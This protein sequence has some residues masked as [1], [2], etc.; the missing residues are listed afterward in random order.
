MQSDLTTHVLRADG[1]PDT[2]LRREWLITNGTGAFA[3]GT[4]LGCP[5]RRYHGLLVAATQPPVGRIMAL[6]QMFEQL[7]L[8]SQSAAPGPTQYLEL[9]TCQFLT[10]E[11]QRVFAP[12]G[13]EH[14]ECF[15]RG[16]HVS[17]HYQW[18]AVHITRTLLLHF[19]TQAAT[20]RYRVT[21]LGGANSTASLRLA[22]MVA[23]R[24]FHALARAGDAAP[25]DVETGDDRVTVHKHDHVA[26]FACPQGTFLE[27]ADWWYGLHYPRETERGQG[28]REDLFVPGAFEVPVTERSDSTLTVALGDEPAEPARD[29]TARAQH[30]T[31]IGNTLKQRAATPLAEAVASTEPA[32][33]RGSAEALSHVLAI[34]ADDFVVQRALRQRDL[35]TIIAGYPWFADWG[36]DTFIA[37]PGLLLTTGRWD[38]ARN[39]LRVFAEAIDDGLVPNRFDDYTEA[40]AHYNTVDASLW[41]IEA[42][43]QYV[44]TTGDTQSWHDWLADACMQIV[45]AYADGTGGQDPTIAPLIAMADDGLITAGTNRTQLTWMDAACGDVVFTPRPGKAVEINALWYNALAGLAEQLPKAHV[46]AAKQYQNLANRVKRHFATVF[47]SDEA[48]YLLDHI[49]TDDAGEPQPDPS[50]RPNQ[51]FACALPR[52][53]LGRTKQKQV[54][55]AVRQ[56]LL[57]PAGLRTLPIDDPRYHGRY[58]GDQF[59]R[60]KA[61]H[62]GT[63][64]PWLI[65]PYCEA[66]LRTG[67]FSSTARQQV[68]QTL[69]PLLSSLID[70]QPASKLS[71]GPIGQLAEIYEANPDSAGRFHPVGC[72][73]QGWSVAELLRVGDLLSQTATSR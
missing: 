16:M 54:V 13:H 60:D 70:G 59:Q 17:W 1:D 73:A 48:G 64:W 72:I 68:Q 23:L 8:Q 28:D 71:P 39:V 50:L 25:F 9:S 14:L 67:Q 30:L 22:P 69:A 19:K 46:A 33:A 47:W 34:A 57:T 36:R 43:L 4:A 53:P 21:G 6:N 15:E 24:D 31:P 58:G 32:N 2:L 18:G 65:G 45:D 7:C 66:V 38:E 29:T 37:L 56:H 27:H 42:A 20:L 63:I 5:T 49:N 61:Y 26:T 10:P 51:I 44:Q 35:S 11:G 12:K 62:Q 41:F 40:A 3:M 55:E 52:S